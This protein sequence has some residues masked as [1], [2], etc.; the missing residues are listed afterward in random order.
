[1][2]SL[3]NHAHRRTHPCEGRDPSNLKGFRIPAFAG[4]TSSFK[5]T[6]QIHHDKVLVFAAFVP[7]LILTTTSLIDIQI[8]H[9]DLDCNALNIHEG[10]LLAG[11]VILLIT[12][13]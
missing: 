1:F 4:M 8:S 6:H 3:D 11:N 9:S 5:C 2:T 12:Q 13:P 10:R 7:D